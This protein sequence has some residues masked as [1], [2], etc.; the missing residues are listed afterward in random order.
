MGEGEKRSV[1]GRGE[2]AS[3]CMPP[4]CMQEA[5][6]PSSCCQYLRRC[7]GRGPTKPRP[8]GEFVW[9]AAAFSR[10]QFRVREQV[11]QGED[12]IS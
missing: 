3:V 2:T 5:T 11:H 6:R 7:S 9:L 1:V 4:D 12:R 10:S 8:L